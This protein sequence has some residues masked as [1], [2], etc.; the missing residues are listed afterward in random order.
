MNLFCRRSILGLCQECAAENRRYNVKR[1]SCQVLL[2]AKI[3]T[4]LVA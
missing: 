2:D 3:L 4:S 1:P